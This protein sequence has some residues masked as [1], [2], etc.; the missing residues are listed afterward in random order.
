[1]TSLKIKGGKALNG[2]VTP[3]GNKNSVLPILCASLLTKDLVEIENVPDISDVRKI[4]NFFKAIGSSVEF[5]SSKGLARLRHNNLATQF[6]PDSV[7]S[8]MRS[9]VLLFAPLL[10][11]LGF[12][13]VHTNTKGCALGAREIDPHLSLLKAF[14]YEIEATSNYISLRRVRSIVGIRHWFDYASVTATENF[15]MAASTAD[16]ESILTNAASEPHVQDLCRFLVAMGASIDGIGSN[17]VKISGNSELHGCTFAIPEDH[18]EVATFL[19]IGAI[20]GGKIKVINNIQHH[21]TLI[22]HAFSKLGITI[23]HGNG[24]SVVNNG[25]PYIVQQPFTTNTFT[26]IEGAPWPY[27]PADLLP[28]FIALATACKGNVLFWNKVYEGGLSWIPELN[29]FGAFAHL[30]DPHKVIVV[31]NMPLRPATVESPYI[32]RAAIALLMVAL[33]TPGDSYIHRAD[34][35]T[36]AHPRFIEKLQS[37]GAEV[38]W[39]S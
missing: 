3:S 32:I 4:L 13:K 26:K 39:E 34:P 14:G 1:M 37:L 7:P 12:I 10:F 17:L 22:D 23:E 18:H 21:L 5:E 19:A 30:C 38:S 29:K 16:G 9:S 31:G 8:A 20:T 27:F 2:T 28:P 36:R 25:K 24:Y 6:S 33:S 15:L 35:I 11:R